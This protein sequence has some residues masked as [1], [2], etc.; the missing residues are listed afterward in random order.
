MFEMAWGLRASFTVPLFSLSGIRQYSDAGHPDVERIRSV[1]GMAGLSVRDKEYLYFAL[2]KI[3]DDCGLYDEAFASYAQGNS[4]RNATL[5]YDKARVE[6]T[7]DA[8]VKVFPKAFL[9]QAR[10][11][12]SSSRT[13]IFIVGMPRSGTTLMAGIL[14]NHP[15]IRSAGELKEMIEIAA[16]LPEWTGST[17]P[18]PQAAKHIPPEVAAKLIQSYEARLRRDVPQEV[19]YVI[20]KHPLNFLHL[21]LIALLFP[22]ATVIHCQ[23]HPLD[24]ALSNYFQLFSQEYDYA[25]DLGNIAHYYRQYARVMAHWREVLPLTLIEV[26]Y[27]DMV[28]DTE[29]VARR[30][31]GILNLPWD[32]RCLTPHTNPHAVETASQWQVRQPIYTHALERWK[33]YE[34]YLSE[35]S[36]LHTAS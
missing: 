2:G 9:A 33:K 23:R 27:G 14:S 21:G 4:L 29:A 31:L 30:V 22:R 15:S 10:D 17:Q 11:Y 18:Y 6:A 16:R 19:P 3:Y 1:L 26:Q 24:T 5:S 34:K 12:G 8:I 20:D 28:G 32:S 36:D 25:F 35:F 7:A 13:P